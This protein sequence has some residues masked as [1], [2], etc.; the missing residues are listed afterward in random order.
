MFTQNQVILGEEKTQEAVLT[1]T[2]HLHFREEKNQKSTYKGKIKF[3][4]FEFST[5]EEQD[6]TSAIDFFLS[7]KEAKYLFYRLLHGSCREG[8]TFYGGKSGAKPV[9]KGLWFTPIIGYNGV[10]AMEIRI[11][12]GEGKVNSDG[13][14]VFQEDIKR[15]S[16]TITLP[17][18]TIKL[19]AF[20]CLDYIQNEEVVAQINGNPLYDQIKIQPFKRK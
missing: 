13:L 17:I 16:V 12:Q 6:K 19:L 10:S 9:A 11:I 7:K 15:E 4:I 2:S 14:V 1:I 3:H 5:E 8:M 18:D 20:E